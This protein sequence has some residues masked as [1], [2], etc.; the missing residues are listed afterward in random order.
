MILRPIR[1]V[2]SRIETAPAA[3]IFSETLTEGLHALKFKEYISH[4]PGAPLE[5]GG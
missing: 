2:A 1:S 4:I 3:A 5:H